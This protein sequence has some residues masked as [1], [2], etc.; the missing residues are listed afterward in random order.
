L[1]AVV[2]S[3]IAGSVGLAN[4]KIIHDGAKVDRVGL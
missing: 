4:L 1:K 2:W 3:Q